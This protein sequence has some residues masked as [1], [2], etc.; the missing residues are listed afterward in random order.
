MFK[1]LIN[2][3]LCSALI[4]GVIAPTALA[5]TTGFTEEDLPLFYTDIQSQNFAEVNSPIIFTAKPQFDTEAFNDVSYN[6]TFNDGNRDEGKQVAHT[7]IEPGA[8]TIGL[9][10]NINGIVYEQDPKEIFVALKAALLITDKDNEKAKIRSILGLA[11]EEN[12]F[13]K[14]V[15]SFSSQSQFLSEEVL[16]RKIE[17]QKDSIDKIET[18][19]VWTDGGS[20]LNAL[21]R[22]QQGQETENAFANTSIILLTE[23]FSNSRRVK[24]Q[25]NQL[26][27]KEILMIQE[28]GIFQYFEDPNI[29]SFKDRLDKSGFEYQIINKQKNRLTPFNILSFFLDFLTEQGIPDNAIILVLLLPIIATAI[30]FM[31][32]VIG[33]TTLGIYTPTIITLTF[34]ILGLKFGM[35]VLFFIVAMGTIAHKLVKPLKLLYIPKMALIITSVSIIIFLLLTV[36]VYLNLFDIEFISLA[37]FPVVIMGTMTEKFVSIRSEKGLSTSLIMMIETFFVS[38]VAYFLAGGSID[39]YFF[40]I[41]WSYLQNLVLNTPEVVVLFILINIYL[42]RWTG[43]RLTEYLQFRDVLKDIVE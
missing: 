15:E 41:Q 20:G 33:I 10:V 29:Q 11:Q 7:F 26:K 28:S 42:G 17:R 2:S 9:S 8:Y 1:K 14:T 6:W 31:K 18:I 5:Q 19:I 22:Y 32:Q 34:L 27:P 16:A 35:V 40:E 36:T 21:S 4:L 30:A 12:V 13:I 23:D 3:I 39:L 25:F 38:L 43:L 37:I 24:R